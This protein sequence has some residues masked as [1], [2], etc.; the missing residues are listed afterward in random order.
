MHLPTHAKVDLRPFR[1][2]VVVR[3]A[4]ALFGLVSSVEGVVE[5][6]TLSLDPVTPSIQLILNH[7]VLTCSF[8][9]CKIDFLLE[10][11]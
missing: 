5:V 10:I 4:F 2:R 6:S 7:L 9:T 1:D 11:Y 8:H 3:Y